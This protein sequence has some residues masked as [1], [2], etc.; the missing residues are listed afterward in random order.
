MDSL[1]IQLKQLTTEPD[2]K[3]R[4]PTDYDDNEPPEETYYELLRETLD[5]YLSHNTRTTLLQTNK[6]PENT[7]TMTF[8]CNDQKTTTFR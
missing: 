1:S 5:N 6:T 3:P 2:T 7:H 4:D 8:P